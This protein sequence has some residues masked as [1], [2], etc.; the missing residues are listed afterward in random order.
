MELVL[1]DSEYTR[2][3][4]DHAFKLVYFVTL[5]RDK[6]RATL[7]VINTGDKPFSFTGALHTYFAAGYPQPSVAAPLGSIAHRFAAR[8]HLKGR[9]QGPEGRCLLGPR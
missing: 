3:I 1:T 7:R 9:R 6:L 2:G 5:Q 4:W 8:R